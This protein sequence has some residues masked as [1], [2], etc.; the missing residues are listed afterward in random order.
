LIHTVSLR[1]KIK[2][3]KNKNKNKKGNSLKKG[4]QPKKKIQKILNRHVAASQYA[5]NKIIKNK[6][7]GVQAVGSA[8]VGIPNSQQRKE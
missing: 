5:T 4:V 3:I 1:N 8:W 6:N 2:K 7:R